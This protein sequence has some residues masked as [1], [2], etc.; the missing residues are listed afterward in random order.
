MF[1]SVR[2]IF[3]MVF[4]KKIISRVVCLQCIHIYSIYQNQNKNFVTLSAH[5]ELSLNAIIHMLIDR[6]YVTY[7]LERDN[8]Q[9]VLVIAM[10]ICKQSSTP[11]SRDLPITI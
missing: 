8:K 6:S 10:F 9:N 11:N 7:S 1:S 4:K 2:I 3:D 5:V